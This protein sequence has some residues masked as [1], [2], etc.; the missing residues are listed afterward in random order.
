MDRNPSDTDERV[1]VQAIQ[2][3]GAELRDASNELRRHSRELGELAKQA[4]E[5]AAALRRSRP[6]RQE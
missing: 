2:R 1:I 3:E 6:P 5:R 4:R